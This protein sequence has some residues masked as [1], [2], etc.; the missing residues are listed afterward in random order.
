MQEGVYTW[1]LRLRL[2]LWKTGV[3][4]REFLSSRQ[5]LGL[6]N[7]GDSTYCTAGRND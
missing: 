3:K 2:G 7:L 4:R 6:P 1:R 5:A